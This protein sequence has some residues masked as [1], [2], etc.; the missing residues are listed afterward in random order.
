MESLSAELGG[1]SRSILSKAE[2]LLESVNLITVKRAHRRPNIY[3]VPIIQSVQYVLVQMDIA[4]LPGLP[5]FD[6]L[7]L[8]NLD[9]LSLAKGYAFAHQEQMSEMFAVHRSTIRRS[10][11]R[12]ENREKMKVDYHGGGRKRGNTYKLTI[13]FLCAAEKHETRKKGMQIGAQKI[14]NLKDFKEEN[15]PKSLAPQDYQK[16]FNLLRQYGVAWPVAKSLAESHTAPDIQ[17]AVLNA[18]ARCRQKRTNDPRLARTITIA[19][20]IVAT[21][22]TARREGHTVRQNS[23]VRHTLARSRGK[24]TAEVLDSFR[25]ERID[26]LKAEQIRRLRAV[27][28]VEKQHQVF[29][30]VA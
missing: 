29:L 8:A 27:E 15:P 6:K 22:N 14:N 26:T 30:G 16:K 10:I 19:G 21:L 25:A 7:V 28:A 12:L 5:A 1:V 17:N 9:G 23:F 4:A 18:V 13:R 11:K 2:R 3:D 20:Y 24:P